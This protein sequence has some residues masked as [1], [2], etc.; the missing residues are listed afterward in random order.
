MIDITN[1]D[2]KGIHIGIKISS[3]GKEQLLNHIILLI[4]QMIFMYSRSKK[5]TPTPQEI[6]KRI[7]ESR[8]EEKNL[9]M[10]RGTL[11]CHLRKWNYFQG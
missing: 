9:A 1:I 2:W 8:E 6:K 7:L 11:A 4:K 5:R 3:A 10:G